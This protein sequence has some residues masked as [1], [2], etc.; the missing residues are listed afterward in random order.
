MYGVV[1]L[2]LVIAGLEGQ[3]SILALIR[4]LFSGSVE[5]LV[6]SLGGGHDLHASGTPLGRLAY[7]RVEGPQ[8]FSVLEPSFNPLTPSLNQHY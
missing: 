4:D 3:Q 1:D 5:S 2:D 8:S 6:V 7:H